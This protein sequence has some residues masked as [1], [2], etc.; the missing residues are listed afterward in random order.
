MYT[1]EMLTLSSITCPEPDIVNLNDNSN[2]LT[3]PY[4]FGVQQPI[5]PPSFN[6]LNQSPNPFNLSP[7]MLVVHTNPTQHEKS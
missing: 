3:N 1:R 4:R 2:D 7:A 6:D 5:V